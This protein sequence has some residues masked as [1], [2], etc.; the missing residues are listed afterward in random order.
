MK[1]ARKA[2]GA[3]DCGHDIGYP[4]F[5]HVYDRLILRWD[6][7]SRALG[8]WV[9]LHTIRISLARRDLPAS[10]L[11]LAQAKG[12]ENPSLSASHSRKAK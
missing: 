8:P 5:S 2:H 12:G 9:W 10:N 1:V 4:P 7:P 11:D 3:V 6:N